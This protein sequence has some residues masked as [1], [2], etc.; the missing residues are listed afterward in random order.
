MNVTADVSER[1]VA[2]TCDPST[3][4]IVLTV[5]GIVLPLVIS[6]TLPFVSS[7]VPKGIIQGLILSI[8]G[9]DIIT[10]RNS[11]VISVIEIEDSVKQT[12]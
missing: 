12:A 5:L 6:E 8:R 2:C 3:T 9:K 11:V 4:S 7:V 1:V 10:P